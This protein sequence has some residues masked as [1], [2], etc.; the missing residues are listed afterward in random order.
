M[1]YKD[2]EKQRAATL[3]YKHK[4]L[5]WV[6]KLK[7]E[8]GCDLCG[9]NKSPLALQYHHQSPIEK[10]E[11]ISKMANRNRSKGDILQEISKCILVCANCH[12]VLHG[13]VYIEE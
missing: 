4:K 9:Y 6:A 12:A 11:A 2:K 1:P 8:R 3:G 13:A 10:F 5:A 7:I